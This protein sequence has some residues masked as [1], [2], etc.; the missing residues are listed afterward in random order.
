V[1]D[2][3]PS[4]GVSAQL[5]QYGLAPRKR[6]GQNFLR[7]R[8]YLKRMLDAADVNAD[9]EVLEIGAGTGVLT[10]ALMERAR[11]VV[12]VELDDSLM[13]ML[14]A[15]L[16]RVPNLELWHANALDFEPSSNFSGPY[17]LLGNIPYYI[18]GPLVRRYLEIDRKPSVLIVMVQLE[19]A[20]RIIA[21]PGQL[22]VLGVSVQYYADADLVARV[23]A[24]AFYPVPKVDSAILRL[25]PKT[26]APRVPP[27]AFFPIVKAGF[28]MKR[29]QIANSL[30]SGLQMSRPRTQALLRD[31]GIEETRRAQTLTV[32]EWETLT[33]VIMRE[34]KPVAN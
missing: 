6:L 15:E 13:T 26:S 30:T 22:S 18:T 28:S 9:D 12:A 17:K 20:E 5:R 14:R 32:A 25:R 16:E 23:P 2:D 11:R 3:D 10:R 24:G 1:H 33:D 8:S 19:V 34:P 29:K 4:D 27:Q 31:A 7:D 21:R